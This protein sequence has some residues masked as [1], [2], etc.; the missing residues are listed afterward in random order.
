PSRIMHPSPAATYA[1][2]PAAAAP[3][4][5]QRLV[6]LAP[7]WHGPLPTMMGGDRRFFGR[8]CRLV[9]RPGLGPV[10]YRLNVNRFMVRRMGAGHV[11][12]DAAFLNGERLPPKLYLVPQP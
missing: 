2:Q 1:L 7:T 8:L 6:L 4:A 9:D 3:E 5:T 12:A 10:V 11:Y